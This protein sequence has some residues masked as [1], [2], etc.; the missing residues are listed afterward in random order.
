MKIYAIH[1]KSIVNG[2]IG[3]GTKLFE[4]EV[5]ERLAMELNESYPDINHEAVISVHST[6]ESEA[7]EPAKVS[8]G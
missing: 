2:S 8:L 4:R 1:W 7:A 5:A 3:T 6:P